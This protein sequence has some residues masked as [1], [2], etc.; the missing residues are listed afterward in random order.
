MTT[1]AY[2]G[3][4]NVTNNVSLLTGINFWPVSQLAATSGLKQI[5][6][7]LGPGMSQYAPGSCWSTAG[8]VLNTESY[9]TLETFG[10]KSFPLVVNI[11]LQN[12]VG[13]QSEEG[14]PVLA[15]LLKS[16]FTLTF[17]GVLQTTPVLAARSC[18][19]IS[20]DTNG[21]VTKCV[22]NC[23]NELNEEVNPDGIQGYVLRIKTLEILGATFG[24]CDMTR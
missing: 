8:L 13:C 19:Y 1:L 9:I 14:Y 11:T 12:V 16:P 4:V 7:P 17:T 21:D 6:E 18:E 2:V 23:K 20:S 3:F 15:A 22:F 10:T 24:V 5:L